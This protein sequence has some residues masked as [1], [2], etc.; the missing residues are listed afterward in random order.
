MQSTTILMILA[1]FSNNAETDYERCVEAI[2]CP[3]DNEDISKLTKKEK[4]KVMECRIGRHITCINP[5][6]DE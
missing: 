1:L 4:Q 2:K 6:K 5:E 3:H